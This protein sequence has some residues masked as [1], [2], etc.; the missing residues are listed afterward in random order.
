MQIRVTMDDEGDRAVRNQT[1]GLRG[2]SAC[3]GVGERFV[4]GASILAGTPRRR[5]TLADYKNERY[6]PL[7]EIA[8]R[9]PVDRYAAIKS[10]PFRRDL[11]KHAVAAIED[12][13]DAEDDGRVLLEAAG[14][15]IALKS[16]KAQESFERFIWDQERADLRMEAVLILTEL[17]APAGRDI[18]Q[19]IAADR[20]FADDEIRQAAVWGLG[21]AGLQHYE[22]LVPYVS[23]ADRD[24]ALHAIAGFGSDT[25]APVIDKL[26]AALRSGEKDKAAAASEALRLIDSHDVLR[27]L[28][29]AAQG[30]NSPDGWILATLGRLD[31]I[32]VQAA[33]RGTPLLERIAPL[34]LLSERENWLAHD[35]I[36]ID[37]KFL[38]KQNL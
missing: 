38:L 28:I 9:N 13:L 2:K 31:P 26:I 21:K 7:G 3:V 10:L 16:A 24:V 22:D 20:R 37:L 5:A 12:R 18:L 15:G 11:H 29:E 34:L 17:R 1:Y 35:T 19:T 36:D 8:A 23:D 6:D 25:P 14:A 27:R 30:Q 32:K 33:L 4:A